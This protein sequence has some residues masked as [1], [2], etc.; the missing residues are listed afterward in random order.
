MQ[1]DNPLLTDAE[2]IKALWS[3]NIPSA[4]HKKTDSL[5]NLKTEYRELANCWLP[6]S[7]LDASLG[8]TLECRLDG[9]DGMNI[10]YLLAR[11]LVLKGHSVSVM[12]LPRLASVLKTKTDSRSVEVLEDLSEREYLFLL[13]GIGADQN[14]YENPLGF[15][16]EWLLRTWLLNNKALFIQG[17]GN[18]ATCEW[19]SAGFRNLF[20]DRKVLTFDTVAGS[21]L[22]GTLAN[23]AKK[24][25]TIL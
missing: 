17:E 10:S 23:L 1:T 25:V 3:A 5:Q 20:E 6:N 13:G 18:L 24:G 7:K 9:V 19:W 21:T 11:A 16:I 14:P 12:A 15:E 4:Y 8:K 2:V 22:K